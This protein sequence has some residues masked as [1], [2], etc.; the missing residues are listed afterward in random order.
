MEVCLES[1]CC[2]FFVSMQQ[3]M[4]IVLVDVNVQVVQDVVQDCWDKWQKLIES[5]FMWDFQFKDY[6]CDDDGKY[7]GEFFY[8]L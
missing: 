8:E 5:C 7:I 6:D 4:V 3:M 2:D 1:V